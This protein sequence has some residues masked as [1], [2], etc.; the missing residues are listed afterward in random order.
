MISNPDK[1]HSTFVT[2][3]QVGD[4]DIEPVY[5]HMHHARA[6]LFL[7]RG[8]LDFLSAINCPNDDLIRQGLFLVITRM[9]LAFKREIRRGE[10][11]VACLN[12]RI[13]EKKVILDQHII[14]ERGRLAL[15]AAVE[16]MFLSREAGR[17]VFPPQFFC[18]RF[19][20]RSC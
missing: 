3:Y 18:E 14:N 12:P 7:E 20:S 16:C 1:K 13:E 4:S 15:E 6:L 19:T 17:A 5:D 9:E 8:R 2:S 10:I 11:E